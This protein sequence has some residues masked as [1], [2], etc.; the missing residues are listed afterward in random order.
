MGD[1]IYEKMKKVSA[2]EIADAVEGKA[3][4]SPNQA[5]AADVNGDGQLDDKDIEMMAEA[6]LKLA[7]KISGAIIGMEELTPEEKAVAE[8]NGDGYINLTDGQRLADDARKARMAAAK[9]K[10]GTGKLS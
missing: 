5:A 10:R 2:K 3:N 4:L 8:R 7:N 1:S 9:I 6:Q